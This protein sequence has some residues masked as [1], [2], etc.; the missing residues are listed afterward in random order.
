MAKFN[1]MNVASYGDMDKAFDRIALLKRN[2][3]VYDDYRSLKDDSWAAR[4]NMWRSTLAEVVDSR[5]NEFAR[6]RAFVA[7]SI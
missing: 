5:D 7:S 2:A 6:I 3:H 4:Y 1:Y